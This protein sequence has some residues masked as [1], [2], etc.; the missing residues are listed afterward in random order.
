MITVAPPTHTFGTIHTERHGSAT[1]FLGNPT[2]ADAE[3]SLA[4]VPAPPP[5]QRAS[6]NYTVNTTTAASSSAASNDVR[7]GVGAGKGWLTGASGG[8]D[9]VAVAEAAGG[10]CRASLGKPGG[11]GT[12]AESSPSVR[13]ALPRERLREGTTDSGRGLKYLV[14][15]DPSVFVFGEEV[16]VIAGVKLPLKSAAAC[17][18]EDWNRLEVG[19][20]EYSPSLCR[21]FAKRLRSREKHARTLLRPVS[22]CRRYGPF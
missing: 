21:A 13:G 6:H 3:W 9:A 5:K 1:L 18:P 11:R 19:C 8:S 20:A 10:A 7:K 12:P 16:G 22:A 15:D 2:F 14:V 4:H 17:L